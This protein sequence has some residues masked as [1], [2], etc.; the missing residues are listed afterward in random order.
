M[1]TSIIYSYDCYDANNH[2]RYSYDS[3]CI[4]GGF[5]SCISGE[6]KGDGSDHQSKKESDYHI[7]MSCECSFDE[8]NEREETNHCTESKEEYVSYIFVFDCHNGDIIHSHK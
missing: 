2:C 5:G 7:V 8:A 4:G 6:K 1:R 3:I